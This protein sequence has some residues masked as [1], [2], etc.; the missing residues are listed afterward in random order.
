MLSF[1]YSEG[2][3]SLFSKILLYY[4]KL[5][6][7]MGLIDIYCFKVLLK[8]ISFL[9]NTKHSANQSAYPKMSFHIIFQDGST[10][11]FIE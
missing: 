7:L 4:I 2:W 3:D 11:T 8:L 9:E 5:S 10:L 1:K 6:T